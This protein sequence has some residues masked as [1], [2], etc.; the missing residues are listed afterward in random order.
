MKKIQLKSFGGAKWIFSTPQDLKLVKHPIWTFP[1][2]GFC[3]E[4]PK[5]VL[6]LE[7]VSSTSMFLVFKV[8]PEWTYKKKTAKE[9]IGFTQFQSESFSQN[10]V[11]P[12]H[13]LPSICWAT[14]TPW[15][16]TQ[17]SRGSSAPSVRHDPNVASEALGW[18]VSSPVDLRP[19]RQHRGFPDFVFGFCCANWV[20]KAVAH[21]FFKWPFLLTFFTTF[22][23]SPGKNTWGSGWTRT[24]HTP[25]KPKSCCCIPEPVMKNAWEN[26]SM[27]LDKTWWWCFF[28]LFFFKTS[29]PCQLLKLSRLVGV[30]IEE[31]EVAMEKQRVWHVMK[32]CLPQCFVESRCFESNWFCSFFKLI[33]FLKTNMSY[34]KW[35][36]FGNITCFSCWKY[37]LDG[38]VIHIQ[39]PA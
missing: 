30:E 3:L 34:H 8:Q 20:E 35:L 1:Y 5:L 18:G 21:S 11:H 25:A 27:M 9:C 32:F 36:F 19:I 29:T 14:N 16:S 2:N 33:Y 28:V 7:F 37:P 4:S 10:M 12:L 24:S 23:Q 22:F 38:L 39:N 31:S 13:P 15:T 17:G 26:S 6:M